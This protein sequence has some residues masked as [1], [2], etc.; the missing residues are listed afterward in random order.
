MRIKLF[1]DSADLDE[2]RQLALNPQVKGFTTNPS[3]MRKAGVDNYRA[4][5]QRAIAAFPNQPISLEVFADEF[6]EMEHQAHKIASWGQNI[7]VKIPICNTK[8]V[9]AAPLIGRLTAAGIKVNITAVMCAAQVDDILDSLGLTPAIISIF[10]GRIADTGRSPIGVIN[11]ALGTRQRAYHE[12][13]WASPR[14]VLDVYIADGCGADIIT[15][16]PDL[17]RKLPLEGK[18][19]KEY[20]RLTVKQF[21]DDAK[22]ARYSI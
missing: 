17:I 6:L 22:A 5:A 4:F 9:S 19:L 14:Q 15:C 1:C 10:A 8:G 13:L 21:Y 18:N 12:V 16:T 20:S 3:L 11:Y 2:M 7:F